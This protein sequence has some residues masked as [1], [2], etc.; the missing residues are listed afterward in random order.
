M[1][2]LIGS[3]CGRLCGASTAGSMGL[4]LPGKTAG[5]V[6][7]EGASGSCGSPAAVRS[8]RRLQ[9]PSGLATAG[10]RGT[11]NS[12]IPVHRE[13]QRRCPPMPGVHSANRIPGER[14]RRGP[15]SSFAALK[16]G[17]TLGCRAA[18]QVPGGEGWPASVGAVTD[19]SPRVGRGGWR[20]GRGGARPLKGK[21]R[22][23]APSAG[24]D[25][26]AEK[27]WEHGVG[28]EGEGVSDPARRGRGQSTGR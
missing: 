9:G 24:E 22:L 10:R 25:W 7:G 3:W 19:R 21:G 27:C 1:P 11:Q 17:W 20:L 15:R 8:R 26:P 28:M 6:F 5:G 14:H 23:F 12:C 18:V 2:K 13:Q 16:R 4:A